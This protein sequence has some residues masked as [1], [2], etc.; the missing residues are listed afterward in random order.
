MS[1]IGSSDRSDIWIEWLRDY[2][3]VA[4]RFTGSFIH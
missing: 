2:V 4:T 1:N 3:A